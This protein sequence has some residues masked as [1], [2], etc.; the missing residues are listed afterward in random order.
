M[1]AMSWRLN[2]LE[3]GAYYQSAPQIFLD[4]VDYTS[5]F[6]CVVESLP[7]SKVAISNYSCWSCFSDWVLLRGAGAHV[8]ITN[9]TIPES[10]IAHEIGHNPFGLWH[11]NRYLPRGEHALSDDADMIEYGNPFSVMGQAKDIVNGGDL[12]VGEQAAPNEVFEQKAGYFFG[13]ILSAMM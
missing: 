7:I 8:E 1:M 13:N 2:L 9:G 5:E 10:T 4:G 3:P 12:T 11:A 6:T